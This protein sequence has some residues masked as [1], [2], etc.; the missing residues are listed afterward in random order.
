MVGILGLDIAVYL[1]RL[2]F[3]VAGYFE[4]DVGEGF[5]FDF[6]CGAMEV[7]VLA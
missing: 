2:G 3:A 1:V 5:G 4:G 7:I 6:E